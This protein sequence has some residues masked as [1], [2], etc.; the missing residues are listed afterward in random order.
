[1]QN[2]RLNSSSHSPLRR[3][4]EIK[5]PIS[6]DEEYNATATFRDAGATPSQHPDNYTTAGANRPIY[7]TSIGIN[8]Q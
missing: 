1:M 8:N 3:A 5:S 4:F 6:S 2:R 7:T